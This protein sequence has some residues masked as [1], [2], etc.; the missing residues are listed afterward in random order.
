MPT[1]LNGIVRGCWIVPVL[2]SREYSGTE[3]EESYPYKLLENPLC[4]EIDINV[5]E[6]ARKKGQYDPADVNFIISAEKLKFK[7]QALLENVAK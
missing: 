6:I 7:N 2:I 1:F 4:R 3:P 5:Q